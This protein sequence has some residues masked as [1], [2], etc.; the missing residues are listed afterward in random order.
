MTTTSAKTGS[1]AS[2]SPR[3]FLSPLAPTTPMRRLNWKA[4]PTASAVTRAPAGLCA[5]SRTTVGE[6]RTTS[7]R[8]GEATEAKALRTVS[9]SSDTRDAAR[10]RRRTPR[11]RPAPPPRCAPGGR[12]AAA[13]RPRRYSP[14][15]PRRVTSC[16]PT[17]T[18]RATTPNSSPFAG[19]GGVERRDG[20]FFK[21][22]LRRV[23][24]LLGQDGDGPG[25][26]LDD[27][28]LLRSSISPGVSPSR[29]AQSSPIG[30]STP[31]VGAVVPVGER[32]GPVGA[33][34]RPWPRPAGSRR[35]P[36]DLDIF[37]PFWSRTMPCSA[38]VWN[39]RGAVHL[40]RG[41]TSSSGRRS[42]EDGCP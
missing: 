17:A 16:P 26:L 35:S 27:A 41:R 2:R 40:R 36:K 38:M 6:R 22:H 37:L 11:R 7:I 32:P 42:A 20:S 4:S 30:A 25:V 13:G 1:K 14:P 39:L 33:V 15:S 28:G 8:P 18:S 19:H 24:R 21:N 12:R 23:H 9:T 29:S 5:A 3:T 31:G 10:R 34:L